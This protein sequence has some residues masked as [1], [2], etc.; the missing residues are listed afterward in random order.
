MIPLKITID[1]ANST[2]TGLLNVGKKYITPVSGS[3]QFNAV[4]FEE[5]AVPTGTV[6]VYISNDHD[7]APQNIGTI[8]LATKEVGW[9]NIN[10]PFLLVKFV[11]TTESTTGSVVIY[12]RFSESS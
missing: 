10:V 5:G 6:D 2:E 9:C 12:G 7:A 8:D 1:L 4:A 3:F 11:V